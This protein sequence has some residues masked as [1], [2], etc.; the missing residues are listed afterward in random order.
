LSQAAHKNGPIRATKS[1]TRIKSF[2]M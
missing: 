1:W 2:L